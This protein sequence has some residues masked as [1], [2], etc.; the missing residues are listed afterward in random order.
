MLAPLIRDKMDEHHYPQSKDN[1]GTS[2]SLV[3]EAFVSA[4]HE[5]AIGLE[6]V[7]P[8]C[9]LPTDQPKGQYSNSLLNDECVDDG[10]GEKMTPFKW[11]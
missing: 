8:T 10:K 6:I 2:C 7:V 3:S 9:P 11:N 5:G 1:F 4:A